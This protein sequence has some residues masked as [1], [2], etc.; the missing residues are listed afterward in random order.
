MLR[1]GTAFDPE[2]VFEIDMKADDNGSAHA[3]QK[4]PDGTADYVRFRPDQTP[5][6][7][8]WICRTPDQEGLGV[9]FPAT[10]GVEGYTI[11]KAKGRGVVLDGRA[12]WRA[13]MGFGLLTS[14][15]TSDMIAAINR[16]RAG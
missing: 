15:E 14:G 11:E 1:P 4:H 10:S 12:T 16:V 8:R 3:I 5:M 9:V 2:V 6:A 13:D 7:T